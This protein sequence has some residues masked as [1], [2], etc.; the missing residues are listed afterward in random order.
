VS[1]AATRP[2]DDGPLTLAARSEPEVQELKRS[3]R[4]L[5]VSTTRQMDSGYDRDPEGNSIDTQRKATIEKEQA[6]GTVNVG[7]YV[8]PG[9]SGQAID[10]RPFFQQLLARILERRD[11]DY[12]VI[13]MRSRVF[14]NYI[15]AAIVKQHL[16][17]LGVRVVSA[18]E[19]FGDGV[20]AEAMEAITDVFN[21]LQVRISGQDIKTKMGNKARNGGTLGRAK[22]G[23]RNVRIS[24]DGHKVNTIALD[25]RRAHYIPMAFDLFATGQETVTSLQGKLTRAG[26]RAA[27]DA[28]H[29][30]A[31]I[32]HESLRLLLRDRYYAGYVTYQGAHYPG[33]HQPLITQELYEQVQR[34]LGAHGP[35][36]RQRVHNHYLKG[37]LWCARCRH[38]LV[39][40]RAVGRTGGEYFY[41]FCAARQQHTCDLPYIP[42]D[43]L[44]QAV[45]R[46]I[47]DLPSPTP[48]QLADVRTLVER[49]L[50]IDHGALDNLRTLYTRRLRNLSRKRTYLIDLA[51]EQHWPHKDLQAR[52]DALEQERTDLRGALTHLQHQRDR[53][54]HTYHTATALLENPGHAYEHGDPH[55]RTLLAHALLGRLYLDAAKTTQQLPPLAQPDSSA[56]YT[57]HAHALTRSA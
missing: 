42:L 31:P 1:L 48:T 27:G 11:V 7:E 33:R 37:L 29:P 5:R 22:I 17:K 26:L 20:M 3:V 57:I 13:Y 9:Y 55:T 47:A 52:I 28:R 19:D 39:L 21:W 54:H 30:P 36:T 4:L 12:V 24:I 16:E 8:E 23:Y 46:H 34:V 43:V 14:R 10:K 35:G 45:A 56:I 44:E 6:L 25:P 50:T 49:A 15:E 53:D 32:S 41:F 40:Q 2:Q 51:A 18:K 38:R